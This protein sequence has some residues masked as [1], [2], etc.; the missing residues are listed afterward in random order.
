MWLI[1]RAGIFSGFILYRFEIWQLVRRL[2]TTRLQRLPS[3]NRTIFV[4]LQLDR[5]PL[6]NLI[7]TVGQQPAKD[8]F[9]YHHGLKCGSK[10]PLPQ[11]IRRRLLADIRNIFFV[12]SCV[13]DSNEFVVS[14]C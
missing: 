14:T 9:G 7:V 2:L 3:K 13:G 4:T 5:F 11:V 6:L 10:S 1:E 12:G 8:V